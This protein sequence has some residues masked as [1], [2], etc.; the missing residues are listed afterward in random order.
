MCVGWVGEA[1]VKCAYCVAALHWCF[2]T[3]GYFSQFFKIFLGDSNLKY[4]IKTSTLVWWGRKMAFT[5]GVTTECGWLLMKQIKNNKATHWASL[6]SH[7]CLGNF[8]SYPIKFYK[9][10]GKVPGCNLESYRFLL[11]TFHE[12]LVIYGSN[13]STTSSRLTSAILSITSRQLQKVET[14]SFEIVLS[15]HTLERKPSH[16]QDVLPKLH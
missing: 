11:V 14:D 13:N 1:H 7:F 9:W 2:V 6:N 12:R 15:I 4:G 3:R 8:I 10:L 16:I 5:C